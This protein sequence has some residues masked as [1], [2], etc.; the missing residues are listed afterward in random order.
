VI[1]EVD[2]RGLNCPQPV[3]ETKKALETFNGEE[4]ITIVDNQV[5]RDNV[6]KFAQKANCSVEVEQKGDNYYIKIRKGTQACH[7]ADLLINGETVIM[8]TTDTFGRGS[9]ELGKVLLKSY[10]YALVEGDSLPAAMLFANGGV[11]LTTEGSEV[12]E[13]LIA[14]EN[15]GV[16]ILSCGLCLDFFNLKDKLVVGQITNMYTI[17]EKVMNADKVV[18]I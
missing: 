14:L 6:V 8:V 10:I 2:C 3:I 15:K 13:H 1:K 5:A 12:L 7:L 11:K 18:N 9:D 16:E 4:L 17:N